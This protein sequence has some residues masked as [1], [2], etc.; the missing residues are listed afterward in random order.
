MY[1]DPALHIGSRV[2]PLAMLAAFREIGYDVDVV[3]GYAAERRSAVD[4]VKRKMATGVE[5]DFLY[6]ETSTMPTWLTETH[7]LPTYPWLDFDLFYSCQRAHVPVGLFYRDVHWRFDFYRQ[8]VKAAHSL[9]ARFFYHLDLLAYRRWVDVLFLPHLGML[10]Y[11]R[12]WPGRKPVYSLPPAS[13]AL[14]LPFPPVTDKLKLLYVGGVLPPVYNLAHLLE[15]VAQSVA[16]GHGIHLTICCPRDQWQSRPKGYDLWQGDWLSVVHLGGE[17][18][19]HLYA[20][21]HVA[22]VYWVPSPYLS[23]AMP[24]KLFEAVGFG[25]PLI[26]V[27]ETAAAEFVIAEECGWTAACFPDAL[28]ALLEKL[29]THRDELKQK[30][31]NVRA[32][33]QR[34]TWASRAQEAADVLTKLHSLSR[35]DAR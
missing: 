18:L 16:S 12:F 26:V 6:S 3:W 2:R 31:E 24:V 28:S 27:D 15:G 5:Y 20:S 30:A 10:K 8:R 32:I 11:V 29:V 13:H 1:V 14:D 35:S 23:F 17:K 22:I 4:T 25:R 34:H 33:R 21:H 19:R 9:V 7:H